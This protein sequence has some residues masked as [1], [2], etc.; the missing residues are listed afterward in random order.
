MC[1]KGLIWPPLK[2]K[3]ESYFSSLSADWFVRRI[4]QV[5]KSS[6]NLA[7]TIAKV[8]ENGHQNRLKKRIKALRVLMGNGFQN[9]PLMLVALCNLQ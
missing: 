3:A 1:I 6:I 9:S 2:P 7:L 4:V 5:Y 8:T